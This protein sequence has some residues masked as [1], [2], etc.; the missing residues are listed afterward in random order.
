MGCGSCVQ[1][2]VAAP[3]TYDITTLAGKVASLNET[4]CLQIRFSALI[5]EEANIE[6]ANLT[7]MAPINPTFVSS[8]PLDGSTVAPPA[9]AVNQDTA[10]A[11]QNETGIAVDP[12]NPNC[13]VA[14]ANDYVPRAWE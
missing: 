6:A 5:E 8:S 2:G 10:D 13:V 14:A 4:A 12:N 9:V 3:P 11:P 7:P 1:I